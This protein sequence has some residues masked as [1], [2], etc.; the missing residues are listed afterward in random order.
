M[1]G[2]CHGGLAVMGQV[3][4]AFKVETGNL[5]A[6]DATWDD[7]LEVAEVGRHVKGEAMRGDATRDMNADRG[8]LLFRYRAACESPDASA[9]ADPLCEHAEL[10]T[11]ADEDFLEEAHKVDRAKVRAS[12]A[13][14]IAAQI[15]NWVADQLARTVIGHVPT[16]VD[17][18]DLDTST[19]QVFARSED[20]GA[21]GV[22]AQSEHGGVLKEKQR[23]A[24]A[25]LFAGFY[26]T[27]LDLK[28]LRVRNAAETEEMDQHGW[29]RR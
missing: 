4:G 1:E 11:G 16:P 21:R 9:T 8:D 6:G 10:T 12:L 14:E 25:P 15:E 27:L 17:L 23:V 2:V 29:A 13:G 28:R 26:D 18:V 3:L 5:P 7:P 20:V 22:P 24:D 19:G